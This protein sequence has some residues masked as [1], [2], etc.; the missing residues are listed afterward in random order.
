MHKSIGL[1]TAHALSP[2]P[3]RLL[4]WPQ[5]F[6][7]MASTRAARSRSP[8]QQPTTASCTAPPMQTW[9]QTQQFVR[10]LPAAE[11][12]KLC[13]WRVAC[14]LVCED[15]DCP[16]E[17][18]S[19]FK[20]GRFSTQYT[21]V[22]EYCP[23]SAADQSQVKAARAEIK[24]RSLCCCCGRKLVPIGDARTNGTW[25]HNDWSSRR[26]H[27]KCWLAALHGDFGEECGAPETDV[28]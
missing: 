19:C 21:P 18:S 27:K 16:C 24:R 25:R 22:G 6:T 11:L 23:R 12:L 7:S 13:C 14:Q 1:A 3:E 20:V 2:A 10:A 28:E 26:Y 15:E 8:A 4:R 5:P 9:E 17:T